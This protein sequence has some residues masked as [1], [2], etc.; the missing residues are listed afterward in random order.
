MRRSACHWCRPAS[1]WRRA[2]AEWIATRTATNTTDAV[3]A[4]MN[5]GV[6]LMGLTLAVCRCA[7]FYEKTPQR[8]C[9]SKITIKACTWMARQ[10]NRFGPVFSSK[11]GAFS[12]HE[13]QGSIAANEMGHGTCR[14]L[15]T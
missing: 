3:I 10:A 14:I 9:E 11:R 5:S 4:A 15:A 8:Q 1:R 12:L 6:M 2:L 7:Q 13:S